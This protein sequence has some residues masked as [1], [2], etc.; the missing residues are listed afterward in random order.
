MFAQRVNV[1]TDRTT[2]LYGEAAIDCAYEWVSASLNPALNCFLEF[3]V[4]VAWCG[5]GFLSGG[6]EGVG[7]WPVLGEVLTS[8]QWS[9]R[10]GRGLLGA[11][12]T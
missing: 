3:C 6:W 11:L 1:A 8:G 12:N 5:R 9:R 2:E 7:H 4:G 10:S